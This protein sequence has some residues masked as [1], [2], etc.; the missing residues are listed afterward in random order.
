MYLGDTGE[1]D[2]GPVDTGSPVKVSIVNSSP[3]TGTTEEGGCLPG[4]YI[5]KSIVNHLRHGNHI[6]LQRK[7]AACLTRSGRLC[8]VVAR[9]FQGPIRRISNNS[10]LLPK[11]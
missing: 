2:A 11:E 10:N 7:I 9:D 3:T 5:Y 8:F 6:V 1:A 4:V